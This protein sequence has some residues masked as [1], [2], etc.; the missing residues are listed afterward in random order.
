[1]STNLPEFRSLF[2]TTD[3]KL[4]RLPFTLLSRELSAV[5]FVSLPISACTFHP[6]RCYYSSGREEK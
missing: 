6:S 2:M 4:R 3:V 5:A 1:M